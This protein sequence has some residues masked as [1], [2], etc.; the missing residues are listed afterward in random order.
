M[1]LKVGVV[2]TRTIILYANSRFGAGAA[3]GIKVPLSNTA[4]TLQA[5][6]AQ[7]IISKSRKTNLEIP[8]YYSNYL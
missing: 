8:A 5:K 1:F 4:K 6:T 2:K 7:E 3:H